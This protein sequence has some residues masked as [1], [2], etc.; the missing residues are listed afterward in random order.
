M[1][2]SAE[3]NYPAHNLHKCKAVGILTFNIKISDRLQLQYIWAVLVFLTS[4]NIMLRVE[5]AKGLIRA[6]VSLPGECAS[7]R[8]CN[9]FS[10]NVDCYCIIFAPT[11]FVMYNVVFRIGVPLF[12]HRFQQ[13]ILLSH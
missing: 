3:T 12:K 9:L 6:L 11:L 2:S 10:L 13:F 5:H 7:T 1:L 8:I 4:S